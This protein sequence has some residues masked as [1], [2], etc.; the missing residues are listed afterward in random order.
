L[1]VSVRLIVSTPESTHPF[2]HV[3]HMCVNLLL[4]IPLTPKI[5]LNE[6]CMQCPL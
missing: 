2:V 5:P 1:G 6:T 4:H 3:L